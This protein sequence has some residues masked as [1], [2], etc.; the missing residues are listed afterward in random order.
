[1]AGCGH[2]DGKDAGEKQAFVDG[3]MSKC[4]IVPGERKPL[5]NWEA[6]SDKFLMS[7]Q[8]ALK[9]M[10]NTMVASSF[11]DMLWL[12]LARVRGQGCRVP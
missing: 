4:G 7:Q 11:W 2:V 9:H 10:R 6:D 1:V 8:P 12:S 3:T 5:M